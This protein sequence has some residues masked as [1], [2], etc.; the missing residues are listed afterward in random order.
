MGKDSD[1]Q[2]TDSTINA[3]TGCDGCELWGILAKGPCYAGHLH[4]GRLA[5][6][7]PTLYASDFIEVRLAPGRMVKAA[8]W[9]DLTGTDRPG[10]PWIPSWMPRLIFVG[11]MG[12]LLSKAV[13]FEYIKSE[14]IDV[15]TSK[16]GRRHV[17]QVLTKQPNRL[18]AFDGW[19]ESQGIDWPE[20]IW[21]GTSVTSLKTAGRIGQ[22]AHV[23]AK[24]RFASLEPLWA[25]VD[26]TPYLPYLSWVVVGGQS[27]QGV[28]KAPAFDVAWIRS[29]RDQCRPAEIPVFVKQL[30][31]QPYDSLR[32]ISIDGPDSHAVLLDLDDNHGGDWSEWPQ[33]LRVREMPSVTVAGALL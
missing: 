16:K 12:D 10:K 28:H 33:D 1:I 24:V 14:L 27:D 11:D 19:L 29:V 23:R 31:S 3:S 22:L 25:P 2:W 7:L 6:S 17:W 8:G 20:N 15:A 30:G 4:E 5:K 13:P 21:V 26:L 9:S 32:R 18:A